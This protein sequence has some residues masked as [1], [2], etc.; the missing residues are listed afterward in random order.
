MNVFSAMVAIA[1]IL[2]IVAIARAWVEARR[3]G[4]TDDQRIDQLE[5]EFRERIET[6]ERIVTDQREQLKRQIDE[7]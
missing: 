5:Q 1:A 3:H 7:L 4:A 6:L 2:G